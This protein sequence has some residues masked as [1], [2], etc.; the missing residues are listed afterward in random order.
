[1]TFYISRASDSWKW[2]DKTPCRHATFIGYD[3]FGNPEYA[4]NIDSAENF[5]EL[6]DEV[7]DIVISPADNKYRVNMPEYRYEIL[8]Y[9]TY[10]E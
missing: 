3:Y 1:M 2:E 7:G 4:I 8:I 6:I 5:A 9:D 10:I